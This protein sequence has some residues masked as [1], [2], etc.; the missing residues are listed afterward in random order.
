MSYIHYLY[1][2]ALSGDQHILCCVFVLFFFVLRTPCYHCLWIVQF[3]LP[4][5]Y[6]LTFIYNVLFRGSFVFNDLRLEMT[7]RSV[8]HH[9]SNLLFTVFFKIKLNLFKNKKLCSWLK[10]CNEGN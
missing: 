1:L 10:T 4:L 5:R 7:V 9:C 6:Y 2:S 3:G 8:D